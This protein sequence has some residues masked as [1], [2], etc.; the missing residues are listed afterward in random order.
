MFL[1]VIHQN[2]DMWLKFLCS[3]TIFCV[4]LSEDDDR[5]F[6]EKDSLIISLCVSK[7]LLKSGKFKHS[8]DLYPHKDVSTLGRLEMIL[9]IRKYNNLNH[10]ILSFYQLKHKISTSKSVYFFS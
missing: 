5:L 8:K 7:N 4:Q 2:L 6:K 3:Q 9:C 1:L 10:V